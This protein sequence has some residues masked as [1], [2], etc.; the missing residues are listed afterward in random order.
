MPKRAA[1]VPL[2]KFALL[3]HLPTRADEA[4]DVKEIVRLHLHLTES[5][6]SDTEI[7]RYRRALNALVDKDRA[8]STERVPPEGGAKVKVFYRDAETSLAGLMSD[9]MALRL[10]QSEQQWLSTLLQL[11]ELTDPAAIQTARKVLTETHS[12]LKHL[13]ERL[14]FVPD[15]IGRLPAKVEPSV[16][17][18]TMDAIYQ[19]RQIRLTFREGR[20]STGAE[21]RTLTIHRLFAKDGALYLIGTDGLTDQPRSYALHR[22]GHAEV[23]HHPRQQR[24]I[25]LSAI[26]QAF[27]SGHPVQVNSFP[28]QPNTTSA[29]NRQGERPAGTVAEW[30]DLRLRVAPRALFHFRERPLTADQRILNAD[31]SA[32]DDL[33]RPTG[34]ND[35]PGSWPIVTAN[36]P[37]TI[38]LLPF[39]LSLGQ[40]VRVE[41]PAAVQE[42]MRV[43]TGA[44]AELY[45]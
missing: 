17:R 28:L 42:Q 6:P 9:I 24:D 8:K 11:P 33:A 29:A 4:R 38:L 31:G 43:V 32:L 10:V 19:D 21:T 30:L 45:R 36:L 1:V 20:R 5:E 13:S 37:Y 18:A 3:A 39:L 44:L 14:L 26:V 7:R 15:G 40:W 23:T 2:D 12:G 34:R 35:D 22:F 41:A 25:D 27:M 16:L